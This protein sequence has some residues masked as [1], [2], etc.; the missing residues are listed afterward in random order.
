MHHAHKN[1][2]LEIV[3][4]VL[5]NFRLSNECRARDVPVVYVR[6]I[7]DVLMA[8]PLNPFVVCKTKIYKS[9]ACDKDKRQI[10]SISYI[11]LSSQ[12]G[13]IRSVSWPSLGMDGPSKTQSRQRSRDI[14]AWKTI[15]EM[16][17]GNANLKAHQLG[18]DTTL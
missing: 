8:V 10:H 5:D 7:N 3:L 15:S 14:K 16:I 4:D 1:K 2:L 6:S 18:R 12:V 11:H 17:G 13:H 9:M